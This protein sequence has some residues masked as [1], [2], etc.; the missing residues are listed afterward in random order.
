MTRSC[1]VSVSLLGVLMRVIILGANIHLDNE[2]LNLATGRVRVVDE[3][4][5]HDDGDIRQQIAKRRI[6]DQPIDGFAE[7]F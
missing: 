6:K 7:V 4:A 2:R 3:I 1:I 5:R